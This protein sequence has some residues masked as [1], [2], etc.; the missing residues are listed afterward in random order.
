MLATRDHNELSVTVAQQGGWQGYEREFENRL[1]ALE[2]DDSNG[3]T[4]RKLAVELRPARHPGI[5]LSDFYA[6]VCR[7]FILN[8]DTEPLLVPYRS[9][10]RQVVLELSSFLPIEKG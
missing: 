6:G 10:E 4:Y 2:Y 1:K 9:I 7:D 3:K 8:P 5:Q